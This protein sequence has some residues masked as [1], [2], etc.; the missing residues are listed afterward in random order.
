MAWAVLGAVA[1]I[2]LVWCRRRGRAHRR[3]P[4]GVRPEAADGKSSHHPLTGGAYRGRRQERPRKPAVTPLD[5]RGAEAVAEAVAGDV[6]V[7]WRTFCSS[8]EKKAG[9]SIPIGMRDVPWPRDPLHPLG[10]GFHRLTQVLPRPLPPPPHPPPRARP[11]LALPAAARCA[12]QAAPLPAPRRRTSTS[13]APSLSHTPCAP[14]MCSV[15]ARALAH[16]RS[17]GEPPSEP[18]CSAGTRTSST[19]SSVRCSRPLSA[20]PSSLPSWR[21]SAPS[22]RRRRPPTLP[23]PSEPRRQGGEAPGHAGRGGACAHP[24]PPRREWRG[25]ALRRRRRRSRRAPS[26][27]CPILI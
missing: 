20:S 14:R 25:R 19:P 4:A 9:A 18:P 17:S 10:L 12:W 6:A 11:P 3:R 15:L 1:V 13:T 16:H 5:T 8:A 22:R 27:I 21:A 26:R 23:W 24:R 7:A 2:A